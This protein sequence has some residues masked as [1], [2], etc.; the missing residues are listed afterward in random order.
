MLFFASWARYIPLA[1]LAGVLLV[2]SYNMSEWRVFVRLFRS[3][4]SD[5]LV[6]LVTFLLTVIVDI[7]VALGVGMVLASFLFMKRMAEVTQVASLL[8]EGDGAEQGFGGRALPAHV[9]AFEVQ[10]SFFFGAASKFQDAMNRV[11]G[12][13]KVLILHVA[14]VLSIDA[15]GLRALEDLLGKL[16]HNGTALILSGAH[17]QPLYAMARAGL[18]ERIGEENLVGGI[19]AAIARAEALLAKPPGAAAAPRTHGEAH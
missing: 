15:T 16:E 11:E 5:V 17:T 4:R 10:G 6:L 13:Q 18:L 14:A 3:P 9:D 2:V 12:R 8:G 7:T 19:D 1:T